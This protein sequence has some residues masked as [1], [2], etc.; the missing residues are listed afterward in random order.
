MSSTNAASVG[1]C[2][3]KSRVKSRP[4][5]SS[6]T[7]LS[8]NGYDLEGRSAEFLR[9][10]T[11]LRGQ[12]NLD[13]IG[14]TQQLVADERSAVESDYAAVFKAL[15]WTHVDFT[16]RLEKLVPD[17]R[18]PFK[19]CCTFCWYA[20]CP[21]SR[22]GSRM[23]AL[24]QNVLYKD[25]STWYMTNKQAMLRRLLLAEAT[26]QVA[27]DAGLVLPPPPVAAGSA[28]SMSALPCVTSR[29][30]IPPSQVYSLG[31]EAAL[32]ASWGILTPGTS[33]ACYIVKPT[34]GLK[35]RGIRLYRPPKSHQVDEAAKRLTANDF[36]NFMLAEYGESQLRSSFYIV[37]R[38]IERPLLIDGRKFDLRVYLLLV[39][40]MACSIGCDSNPG[41]RGFYAFYHPGFVRLSG[42][43]YNR[44][45]VDMSVHLTN[46]CVQQQEQTVLGQ[47]RRKVEPKLGDNSWTPDRV[48]QYFNQRFLDGLDGIPCHDWFRL[49]AQADMQGILAYIVAR[50]SHQ[51]TNS[52]QR[53]Y[54][55]FKLLGCDF[56]IDANLR[57]WLLELNSLP[58]LR[59]VNTCHRAVK[60]PMQ[61]EALALSIEVVHRSA[62][63]LPVTSHSLAMR[64]NFRLI[65]S[66]SGSGRIQSRLVRGYGQR[67]LA[68]GVT[69]GGCGVLEN[70]T[71][72]A[73][74]TT[75]TSLD[76]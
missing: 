50:F 21:Y 46:S 24:Y 47:S 3:N 51:L 73:G 60:S 1:D 28:D 4:I 33:T 41:R 17:S 20:Y 61:R 54:N 36:S 63:G 64:Q 65:S 72:G 13:L 40:N 42:R 71:P 58:S 53:S 55:A 23:R 45:S 11:G 22:R 70:T 43:Q 18:T 12:Y 38:Y 37:Q 35:G 59:L 49:T 76:E 26:T 7:I 57:V 16:S 15:K 5:E 69:G 75:L 67:L 10:Y 25:S 68:A 39:P 34:N 48:N 29:C 19:D 32:V 31:R 62:N 74:G 6:A 44:V 52:Q 66:A 27:M 30:F 56:L 9:R 14:C 8:K 2:N